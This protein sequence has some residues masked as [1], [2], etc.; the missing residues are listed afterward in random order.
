MQNYTASPTTE[1]IVRQLQTSPRLP[2]IAQALQTILQDE[3]AAR[4]RFY[5]MLTEE[6]KAEFI[7]GEVTV[8]PPTQLR[9]SRASDNLFMLL[10]PTY[11]GT[12]WAV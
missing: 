6:Q 11:C 2:Q 12:V 9:H 8:Q 3:A 5:D 1:Q 7:N 4:Q 10:H